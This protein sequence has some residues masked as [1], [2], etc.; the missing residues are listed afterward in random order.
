MQKLLSNTRI[1][2]FFKQFL[3]TYASEWIDNSKITD[4]QIHIEAI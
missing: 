2:I 1:C 4:K 3:E